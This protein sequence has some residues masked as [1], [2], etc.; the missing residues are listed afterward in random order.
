[1][2]P[3]HRTPEQGHTAACLAKAVIVAVE[4]LR[5]SAQDGGHADYEFRLAVQ[6]NDMLDEADS[7][8]AEGITECLCPMVTH[9]GPIYLDPQTGE[10]SNSALAD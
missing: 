9:R 6:R 1:M 3:V 2:Y 4:N 8:L 10:F 7:Y 5:D